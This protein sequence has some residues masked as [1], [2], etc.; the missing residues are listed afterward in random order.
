MAIE[1]DSSSGGVIGLAWW[2]GDVV[3]QDGE[4]EI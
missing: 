1:A 3:E 4:A 2:L